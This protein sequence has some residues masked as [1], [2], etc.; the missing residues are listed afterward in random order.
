MAVPT[1]RA[2]R[3]H[4]SNSW[5]TK[6]WLSVVSDG[7]LWFRGYD[8]WTEEEGAAQINKILEAFTAKHIVVGHTVQ[9]GGRIRPRFDSKV[10][11]IDTGMLSS[12]YPGGRPSALRILGDA[13]LR[14][15]ISTNRSCF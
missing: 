12:S 2:A 7:P 5:D 14:P 11:L 10:F 15:S 1:S 13:K 6:S 9:K 3:L 8:Q 4:S